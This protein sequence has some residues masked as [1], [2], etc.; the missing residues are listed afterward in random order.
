[1]VMRPEENRD[2]A[3]LTG[4]PARLTLACPSSN[5]SIARSL[6]ARK[7]PTGGFGEDLILR[8]REPH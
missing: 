7:R 3:G 5:I 1:M 8:S 2:S 6:E 4:L